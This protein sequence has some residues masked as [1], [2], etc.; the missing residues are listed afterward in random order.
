MYIFATILM[1]SVG[2]LQVEGP[3]GRSP[4]RRARS[5]PWAKMVK[6]GDD[7]MRG[8]RSTVFHVLR[9]DRRA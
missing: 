1:V 8:S 7:G 5:S 9:V 6:E 3:S 4:I 2:L